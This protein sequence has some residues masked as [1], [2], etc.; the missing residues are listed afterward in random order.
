MMRHPGLFVLLSAMVHLVI[1]ED[2]NFFFISVRSEVAL[3]D[4]VVSSNL[5]NSAIP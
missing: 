4:L 3:D 5:D 1:L 2:E